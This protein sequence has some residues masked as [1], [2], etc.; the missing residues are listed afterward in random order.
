MKTIIKT[1]F[2]GILFFYPVFFMASSLPEIFSLS[3]GARPPQSASKDL[4]K[5]MQDNMKAFTEKTIAAPIIEEYIIR[6]MREAHCSREA[7]ILFIQC[8]RRCHLTEQTE[9]TTLHGLQSFPNKRNLF[10][11]TRPCFLEEL[12]N[13]YHSFPHKSKEEVEGRLLYE[14]TEDKTFL[15]SEKVNF[16]DEEVPS[17]HMSQFSSE[18]LKHMERIKRKVKLKKLRTLQ[19]ENCTIL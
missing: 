10:L 16:I 14:L 8:K 13:R 1:L 19:D 3:Y 6:T 4:E 15:F 2:T 11:I 5:R 12:K 9:P 7:A 17:F 18:G